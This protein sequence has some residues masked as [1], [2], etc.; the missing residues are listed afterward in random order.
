[1]HDIAAIR[2]DILARADAAN[3][4]IDR[5][6]LTDQAIIRRMVLKRC[7]SRAYGLR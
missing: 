1:M 7:I 5:P 4:V 2:T 6:Q 3:W